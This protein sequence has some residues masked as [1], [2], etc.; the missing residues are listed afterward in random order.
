MHEYHTPL[1]T[2]KLL[3]QVLLRFGKTRARCGRNNMKRLARREMLRHRFLT[4]LESS[5]EDFGWKMFEL[6]S[7]GF[8]F[9][10][11]TAIEGAGRLNMNELLTPEE[12]GAIDEGDVDWDSVDDEIFD[13]DADD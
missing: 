5:L 3:L 11:I 7:G 6:D 2:A 12:R 8:G 13:E 9:V 4:E 1:E 10:K